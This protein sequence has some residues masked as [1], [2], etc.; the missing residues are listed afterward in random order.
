MRGLCVSPDGKHAFVTHLL[1]NFEMVPFRVDMGWININVVSV[2]DVRQ[3]KVVSTIGLDEYDL[4]AGNPW[5]VACTAD[6]NG[7]REPAGTHELASST[8]P[9]CWATSPAAPCRR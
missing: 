6:G 3:R 9:T 1:S 2:I 8:S 5:D 4:G 7:L